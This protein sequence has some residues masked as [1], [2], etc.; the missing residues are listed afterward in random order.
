MPGGCRGE[1]DANTRTNSE[2]VVEL[3]IDARSPSHRSPAITRLQSLCASLIPVNR[4][5]ALAARI[6][7][8]IF[9]VPLNSER[10][11]RV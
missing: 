9:N 3:S 4:R 2:T 10:C 8:H 7:L 5:R 6:K 11:R 1:C